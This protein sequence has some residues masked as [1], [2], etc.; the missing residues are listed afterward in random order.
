MVTAAYG[1][2]RT[3][4]YLQAARIATNRVVAGVHFPADSVAG[5][6]LGHSIAEYLLSRL[7]TT[8]RSLP[9]LSSRAA[10]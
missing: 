9:R 8:S 7:A 6:L 2:M 4:L 5:R 1:A 10:A 3:Q